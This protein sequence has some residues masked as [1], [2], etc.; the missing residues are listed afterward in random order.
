MAQLSH[1]DVNF[2]LSLSTVMVHVCL[3]AYNEEAHPQNFNA[4]PVK[5]RNSISTVQGLVIKI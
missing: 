5:Y 3:I 1:P 4:V 2:A